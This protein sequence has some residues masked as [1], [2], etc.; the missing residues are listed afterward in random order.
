[1]WLLPMPL[2]FTNTTLPAAIGGLVSR[3]SSWRLYHFTT[4]QWSSSHLMPP[5][6]TDTGVPGVRISMG[7]V[8]THSGSAK[9]VLFL[10]AIPASHLLT[11][12][13]SGTKTWTYSSS[14]IICIAPCKKMNVSRVPLC[15]A[16]HLFDYQKL[17]A[18][19]FL[20]SVL[21]NTTIIYYTNHPWTILV[22][23]SYLANYTQADL[24]SSSSYKYD[25]PFRIRQYIIRVHPTIETENPRPYLLT[26][27]SQ[28]ARST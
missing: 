27:F 22:V 3:G 26:Y 18:G 2:C 4:F 20:V 10:F 19:W 17:W 23:S 14:N 12:F 11:A 5:I 28:V 6:A 15:A 25:L 21:R 8:L 7:S 1:M 13:F 24:E 9:S 16:T